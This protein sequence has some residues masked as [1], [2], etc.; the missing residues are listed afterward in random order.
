MRRRGQRQARRPVVAVDLFCGAGGLTRGLLD[1]GIE[2]VAGYDVDDHCR[3]PYSENNAAAAFYKQSVVELVGKQVREHYPNGGISVLVGC[4][5]CQTF[6]KYTQK[7]RSNKDDPKWTML[8]H[9]AR[10]IKEVRPT[11]VS[12][13]NVPELQL[14]PIFDKFLE[15]LADEGFYFTQDKEKRIVYCPDYGIPQ[16]RRRLVIIASRL[17]QIDLITPTHK[18]E[19]YKTVA[20][21]LRP[22]PAL[23][24]GEVCLTDEL[25]RTSRLSPIN[26]KRIRHS[27]PGGSWREWPRHLVAECH[28][29]KTGTTYPGVYGRMEWDQPSPTITT[30]FY[31]FGNGRFGHPEQNRALSLREGA[32]LQ[33]FPPNY[34]FV[35]PGGKYYVSIIGRMI[36]NAVPVRLGSVIGKSIIRH[37]EKQHV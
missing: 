5:P 18:P 19:N 16:H 6:S 25:H 22:M 7:A 31:G 11:I 8:T 34:V 3:Y 30:Q 9:F 10:L 15:T 20:D 33:S 21:V 36:G 4:A 1:S 29:K 35:P 27:H 26:L 28:K 12:M 14:H 24:A 23:H 17:G 32:L 37:L 13:E 2:V